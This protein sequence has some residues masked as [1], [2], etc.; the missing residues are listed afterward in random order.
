MSKFGK[1]KG[2]EGIAFGAHQAAKTRKAFVN[3]RILPNTKAVL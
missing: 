1:Q 2:A 3:G